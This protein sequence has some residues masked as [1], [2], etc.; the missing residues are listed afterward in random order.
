[1][2][3]TKPI[4]WNFDDDEVGFMD[5]I[6]HVH[7]IQP[8]GWWYPMNVV[9][10]ILQNVMWYF[11][12]IYM[13]NFIEIVLFHSWSFT[14]YMCNLPFVVDFMNVDSQCG[15]V[16]F[17]RQFHQVWCNWSF[18]KKIQNQP[19]FSL[20]KISTFYLKI[21]TCFLTSGQ[22]YKYKKEL[23]WIFILANR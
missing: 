10:S 1:M 6:N 3:S 16:H 23:N 21:C 11:F 4:G 2:Y 15:M 13:I 22:K 20:V 5:E 17:C 9:S 19:L 14:P 12:I 18:L 7:T 8:Y